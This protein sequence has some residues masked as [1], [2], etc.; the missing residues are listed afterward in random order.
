MK[1][2][3]KIVLIGAGSHSFGL[4]TLKDLMDTP[5]LHGSQVVLVDIAADK[6]ER[7]HRLVGRLNE[8]WQAGLSITATTDRREALPGADMVVTSVERKHYEMWT[9]D[10]EVPQKH[11]CQHLYGENGGPGGMFHTL[12]QVPMLLEIARDVEKLCPNAWLLN[13]SNPESRLCLAISRYTTV[14]NVGI[15][16]GAYITQNS[17]ARQVLGL[18]QKDVD[19]KVA[20]INHCHWVM[21]IRRTGTGEDLY[22][23]VRKRM[24]KVDP[25]WEPLSRECLNRFGY[26]PGPADTHVGEYLWWGWKYLRPEQTSWIFKGPESEKA[27]EAEVESLA[28]GSG[29]LK[30]DEMKILR[31]LLI[32][33]GLRWQTID[34]LLSLLDNGNRYVLSLNLPN[35]GYIS[36]LRQGAIVEIPAIVGADRIY[37][38]R[39]GELPTPIAGL[40]ELQLYI[41]DLVV[42]AAVKGDRKAALEALAID[43]N[44]PSPDVAEKILDEML[45]VQK[46]YLPQFK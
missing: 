27:R 1:Q 5:E 36:N 21:D 15:C 30:E 37:G 29:P 18:Q 25:K 38:L 45:I 8:M 31:S 43:P 12:R 32:E 6:L 2:P 24:A 13:L 35:D 39:M 34:I 16:L 46:D 28:R 10:I 22:P 7:M 3:P 17:L 40:L 11:G 23:E 4:M 33:G 20:G 14:K 42:E 44:V 9:L 41:M 26:F 19:I